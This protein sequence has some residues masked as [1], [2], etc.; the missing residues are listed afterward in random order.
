MKPSPP[1][2]IVRYGIQFKKEGGDM[3]LFPTG[4]K[5]QSFK[6]V[7]NLT[8]DKDLQVFL[9]KSKKRR[10]IWNVLLTKW[11]ICN[12]LGVSWREKVR[13]EAQAE[14][15]FAETRCEECADPSVRIWGHWASQKGYLSRG[16][17]KSL[18]NNPVPLLPLLRPS[19]LWNVSAFSLLKYTY[20]F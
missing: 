20:M 8:K 12:P 10:C 14:A 17:L 2:A 5:F 6:C 18:A 13:A 3:L 9:H 16:K 1:K 4:P 19:Y 11:D 7:V 15:C